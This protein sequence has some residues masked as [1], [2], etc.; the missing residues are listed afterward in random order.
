LIHGDPVYRLNFLAGETPW[1]FGVDAA[2]AAAEGPFLS[3][4]Y[5]HVVGA[6]HT[7]AVSAGRTGFTQI[8]EIGNA[9]PDDVRV[10][11]AHLPAR[12]AL[13]AFFLAGL[14]AN[15]FAQVLHA[16]AG[17]AVFVAG[18]LVQEASFAGLALKQ[19]GVRRRVCK[20]LLD[21]LTG[22]RGLFHFGSGGYVRGI[23]TRGGVWKQVDVALGAAAGGNNQRQAEKDDVCAHGATS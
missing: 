3:V 14:A 9:R 16:P 1:A 4:V 19:W 13:G 15:T 2:R 6:A 5:A 23:R 22:T 18:A 8:G 7:L 10:R 12:P 11:G 20:G 17:L 21:Q